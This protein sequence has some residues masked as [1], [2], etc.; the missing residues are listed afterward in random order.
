MFGTVAYIIKKQE[1]QKERADQREREV[2]DR[3]F[4]HLEKRDEQTQTTIKVFAETI[5]KMQ[6]SLDQHNMTLSTLTEGVKT[7]M[8]NQMN[9]TRR[10]QYIPGGSQQ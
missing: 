8:T 3:F 6:A 5:G 7:I 10:C 1:V 4:N 9:D 2:S